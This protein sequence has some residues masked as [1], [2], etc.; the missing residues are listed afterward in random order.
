MLSFSRLNT[1]LSMKGIG[2]PQSASRP[3]AWSSGSPSQG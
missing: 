3:A 1:T 2:L